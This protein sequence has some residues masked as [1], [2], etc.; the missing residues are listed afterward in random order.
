LKEIKKSLAMLEG[1]ESEEEIEEE[2]N[3]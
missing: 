2:T 3:N 1:E